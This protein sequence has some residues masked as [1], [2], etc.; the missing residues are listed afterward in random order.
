MKITL[1]HIGLVVPGIS[2]FSEL[3]GL[4]GLEE[5][6]HTECND[7]QKVSGA[8][9]SITKGEPVY[10]ELLEPAGENSPI[11]NFLNKR[12][13]G[14][15]HLCFE[16]E[17]I[18]QAMKLVEEKGLKI[19]SRPEDCRAYDRNFKREHPNPSRIAFFLLSKNLLCEFI[20][21]GK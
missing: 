18:D 14:L 6:T 10:V 13:G 3:F 2:Q 5:T 16:V 15:H 17:D 12:G 19:I 8:F 4:L 9:V 1:D 11:D 20:E 7:M 21:K